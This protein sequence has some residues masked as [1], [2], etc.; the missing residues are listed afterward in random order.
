MF[1]IFVFAA[2]GAV[3]SNPPSDNF[4]IGKCNKLVL[5]IVISFDF[6]S[7]VLL[8]KASRTGVFKISRS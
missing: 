3:P 8:V 6:I 4:S 2:S 1:D 5:L 7:E